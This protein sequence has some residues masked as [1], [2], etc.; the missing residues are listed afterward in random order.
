MK[1][2]NLTNAI[3][4]ILKESKKP[5]HSK[6]IT[7]RILSSGIWKT[8]GKTPEATVSAR[9]YTDIKDNGERSPF[10]KTGP[11][12][13]TL[14]GGVSEEV[15][16]IERPAGS[17]KRTK[18]PAGSL[19]FLKAAQKVLEMSEGNRPMHYQE[20]TDT[21]LEKGWLVT[22]GKTPEATMNAQL[23]TELKRNKARGETGVF[24]RTSP[25]HYGLVKWIGTGIP[26]QISQQNKEVKKKLHSRLMN[27]NPSEFEELAGQ[28]LAEMGFESI[29]VTKYS[30]DGGIDVR[31]VLQI[32][33]VIRIKMAVQVKRWKGNVQSPTVQQVRGSL[34]AH[35]QGL[36]ITTSNF[37][38]G[39]VEEASQPDKT[40][41]ALMN[42]EQLVTLLMEHG[43]GVRRVTHDLFEME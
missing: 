43:I 16:N 9:I 38:K 5:L 37:S 14:R 34:G 31:G 20:I 13:F 10:I 30:S 42:G 22:S 6:V 12:T 17:V 18:T 1:K 7:E 39:A 21:A 36:I 19:S 29:E 35:E 3:I 32:S 28:L 4:Q 2:T 8:D 15:N 41:V 40:P 25:G 33:D 24:M 23:V 27:M 26:Y 11:L